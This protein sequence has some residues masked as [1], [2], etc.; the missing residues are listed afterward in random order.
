MAQAFILLGLLLFLQP[1][2]AWSACRIPTPA[3]VAGEIIPVNNQGLQTVCDAAPIFHAA[4]L[5]AQEQDAQTNAA[6]SPVAVK[7]MRRPLTPGEI[8][9]AIRLSLGPN[10]SDVQI[11]VLDFSRT[12]VGPGAVQFAKSGAGSPD[13]AEPRRPFLW[14]GMVLGELGN[15]TPC[16]ARVQVVVSRKVV[17]T[18]VRLLAGEVLD[19]GELEAVQ[20]D[21]CPLLTPKDEDISDYVGLLVRRGIPS[22]TILNGDLVETAPLVRRGSTVRVTAVAGPARISL[23]GEAHSDGRMGQ[24][25]QITNSRTGR[26]FFGIVNGKGSVLVEIRD[27][28]RL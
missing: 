16:W 27:S 21:A 15:D 20:A 19:A 13:A 4:Q 23:D 1:Q 10:S 28:A 5:I 18:R 24:G 7:G 8:E 17:R 26:T 25:I 14:R 3:G 22:M 9:R 12:P 6:N 11:R 2:I